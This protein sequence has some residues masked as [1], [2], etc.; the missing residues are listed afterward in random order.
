ME[1]SSNDVF[2]FMNGKKN[3]NELQQSRKKKLSDVSNFTL[4]H[5]PSSLLGDDD[6]YEE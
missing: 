6:D 3:E 4:H 1:T 2:E 5:P